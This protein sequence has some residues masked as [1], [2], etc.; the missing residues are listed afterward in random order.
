MQRALK[1]QA[2]ALIEGNIGTSSSQEEIINAIVKLKEL[3]PAVQASAK[4]YTDL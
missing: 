2:L 1:E 4:A 3:Y